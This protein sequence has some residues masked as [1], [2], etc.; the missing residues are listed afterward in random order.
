MTCKGRNGYFEFGRLDV[1]TFKPDDTF[2]VQIFSRRTGDSAP[3]EFQ[4]TLEELQALFSV[5]QQ[6][7]ELRAKNG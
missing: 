6:K 1:W 5:I 2:Y 7:L 4:G 3:I